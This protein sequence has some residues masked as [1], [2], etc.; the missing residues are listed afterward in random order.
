MTPEGVVLGR[1]PRDDGPFEPLSEVMQVKDVVD[2]EHD[3]IVE[4]QPNGWFVFY[5]ERLVGSAPMEA[6]E[7]LPEL[8]LAVVE[9]LT[10]PDR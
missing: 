10:R 5:D 8:R 3:V 2:H 4:R 9:G 6:G 7:Y 1:R